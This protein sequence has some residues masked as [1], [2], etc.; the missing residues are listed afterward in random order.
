V[1]LSSVVP[2]A[3]L[4]AM[5]LAGGARAHEGNPDYRSSVRAIEPATPGVEARVLDHDDAIELTNRGDRDVVVLGYE[6]EPWI[7]I[8]ANGAVQVDER[9][10]SA[11]EREDRAGVA[12][13]LASYDYA[14]GGE[15][16]EPAPAGGE[17]RPADGPRWVTL[18]RT[19]R[20]AWHDARIRWREPGLPPQV[21]D[22]SRETKIR[23]W[24]VPL[25][26]GTAA[27]AIEGTL[28]WVGEPSAEDGFPVGAAVSLGVLALLAIAAVALVRSRRRA[29]S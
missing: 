3:L 8:R 2:A 9:A 21:T 18:D 7:R 24:R 22:E 19:G 11:R 28:V 6:G 27:G 15:E 20:H 1:R 12:Y 4:A 25:R 14:H 16:H 5:A 29:G 10:A 13:E 23:D 17:D 26:I